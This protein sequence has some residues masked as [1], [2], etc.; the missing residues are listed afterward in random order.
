MA[1]LMPSVIERCSRSP[2]SRVQAGLLDVFGVEGEK[3][4]DGAA[5]F[6]TDCF[7]AVAQQDWRV[8]AGVH[9]LHT[10]AWLW[11]RRRR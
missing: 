2:G 4:D 8:M 10:C 5:R 7:F 6:Q 11:D 1:S 9:A 3:A